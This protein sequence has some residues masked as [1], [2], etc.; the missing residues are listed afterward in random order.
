MDKAYAD[1][2][3][4]GN[5]KCEPRISQIK[6]VENDASHYGQVYLGE[7]IE[8]EWVKALF[9]PNPCVTAENTQTRR[10]VEFYL[11]NPG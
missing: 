6:Q 1:L 4:F 2:Q 11:E 3:I 7:F 5:H 10:F 9:S 8:I